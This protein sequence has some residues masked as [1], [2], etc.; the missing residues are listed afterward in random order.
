MSKMTEDQRQASHADFMRV[1]SRQRSSTSDLTKS[2]MRSLYNAADDWMDDN[3]GS[4]DA[5]LPARPRSK[6]T[7]AQKVELLSHAAEK[8]LRAGA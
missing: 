2:E 7:R 6:L 5:A 3:L 1:L 8:R 4:F